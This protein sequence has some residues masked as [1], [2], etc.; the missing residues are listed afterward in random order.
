M[1]KLTLIAVLYNGLPLLP[2]W[3]KHHY[4]LV[5]AGILI[6]YGSTDGSLEIVEELA[7]GWRIIPA[8]SEYS[9]QGADDEVKRIE[10][11]IDGWKFTPNVTEFLICPDIHKVLENAAK[12]CIIP[13]RAAIMV[14]TP[15]TRLQKLTDAPL[16]LQKHYGIWHNE[17]PL[18]G[19]PRDYCQRQRPI[20][21]LNNA[22]WSI[23]R[24][25]IRNTET[26]TSDQFIMN[27]FAW[28]PYSI[29]RERK[30]K[31]K[32]FLSDKDYDENRGWQHYISMN[33]QDSI[34][35]RISKLSK[36]LMQDKIY[37]GLI[38]ASDTKTIL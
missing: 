30:Q 22:Y 24:H 2:H 7:P 20:H 37:K 29:I 18:S 17:F 3:L 34:F 10:D 4:P 16:V 21:R 33:E 1:H 12:P 5:D 26:E 32:F 15:D 13:R 9:C 35:D 23:G 6:D 27:W 14:D 8:S 31:V 36:D 11:S 19:L 25:F 38:D 28:S